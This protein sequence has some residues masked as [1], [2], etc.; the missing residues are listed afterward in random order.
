MGRVTPTPP[1]SSTREELSL[2]ILS[3]TYTRTSMFSVS[4]IISRAQALRS[5]VAAATRCSSQLDFGF[6]FLLEACWMSTR[7]EIIVTT[8]LSEEI[9]QHT[10]D[11][12]EKRVEVGISPKTKEEA[13]QVISSLTTCLEENKV[14]L[15]DAAVALAELRASMSQPDEYVT[16]ENIRNATES[17]L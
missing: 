8:S 16:M 4:R 1:I 5:G 3:R 7:R 12:I 17:Q 14:L 11:E 13:K 2:L 6:P 9:A 10:L 15:K